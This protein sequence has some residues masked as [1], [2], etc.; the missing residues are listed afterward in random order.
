M[1]NKPI[2]QLTKS[3]LQLLID[4]E[5]IENKILE[6]KQ[7]LDIENIRQS[8]IKKEFVADISAFA[9]SQ[10]GL[11]FFGIEEENINGKNTGK[12]IK[13]SPL[14]IK[15]ID[16][17][18]L[19]LQNIIDSSI[20]PKIIG[21]DIAEIEISKN[22][23][24]LVFHIPQTFNKPFRSLADYKF[25]IRGNGKKD[26]LDVQG[27]KQLVLQ[28]ESLTEKIK[29]FITDR[30]LKIKANEAPALLANNPK[31]AV[32]IIPIMHFE[33][34]NDFDITQFGSRDI[35]PIGSY[36]F[37]KQINFEGFLAHETN[38]ND[39]NFKS[40]Y[41]QVFR[42]YS[43]ESVNASGDL[44][45]ANYSDITINSIN[46]VDIEHQIMLLI[47]AAF[48]FYKS[49]GINPPILVSFS[50]LDIGECE[51]KA[52]NNCYSIMFK[53][54]KN[55]NNDLI[56]PPVY[57]DSLEVDLAEKMKSSFDSIWNAFNIHSSKN[58]KDN[59]WV[60]GKY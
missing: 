45:C 51:I 25:H 52:D 57:F 31:I 58:Y 37:N 36:G 23:Y 12:P 27:L 39:K 24:V 60:G 7:S 47:D 9:N 19:K 42:D 35:R 46:Q 17:T 30:N 11:I 43:I 48:A 50:Y 3:D 14:T 59:T 29:N 34:I 56:I 49:I 1:F 44:I 8:E 38:S 28:S 22:E 32:H 15:N 2:N 26:T 33:N 6:Y 55:R 21:Y 54:V 40:S 10:G 41:L 5:Q 20:E 13:I 18:K 53:S 16:D 4:N